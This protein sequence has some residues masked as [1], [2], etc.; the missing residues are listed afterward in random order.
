MCPPIAQLWGQIYD[1]DL[2]DVFAIQSE[3]ATSIAHAIAGQS[4]GTRKNAIEQAP[5]NDITAFE[6]SAR[7]KIF[8]R[9]GMRK[10][11][12]SRRPICSTRL[13]R[14]IHHFLKRIAC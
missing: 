2:A 14:V 3:I 6:L 10:Q 1:R 4:F 11:I 9:A 8:L 7:A 5:T 12:C 13:S